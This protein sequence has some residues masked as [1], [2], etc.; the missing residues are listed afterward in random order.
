MAHPEYLS[1]DSVLFIVEFL[2]GLFLTLLKAKG[3]VFGLY[4]KKIILYV[5][6]T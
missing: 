3:L 1:W 4:L 6:R 5:F 2:A